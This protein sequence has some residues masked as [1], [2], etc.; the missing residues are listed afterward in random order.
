MSLS[1]QYTRFEVDRALTL[2]PNAERAHTVASI[3]RRWGDAGW[4]FVPTAK[5]QWTSYS[6]DAPLADGSTSAWR[7]LPTFSLDTGL[8]L[9]RPASFFGRDLIQTLEPRAYYVRTPYRDQS[10][11]PLYDTGQH[12]FNFSS[13]FYDNPY[14]GADRIADNNLLTLGL[15]SRL[16]DPASGAEVVRAGVAQRVRLS[17]QR[18]GLPG[19]RR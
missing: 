6:F 15:T 17:D 18:V 1:G 5:F 3:S 13:I 2:Q 9:E 11:L 4:F 7:A 12:E 14:V 16:L 8:R 19:T 10:K